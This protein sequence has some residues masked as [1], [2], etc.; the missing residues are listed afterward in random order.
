M[1]A[2]DLVSKLRV[3]G[4]RDDLC[5]IDLFSKEYKIISNKLNKPDKGAFSLNI[6]CIICR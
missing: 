5:N 6:L 1:E 2:N 3:N 4:T